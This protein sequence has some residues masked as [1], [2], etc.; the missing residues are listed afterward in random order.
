[1]R[2]SLQPRGFENLSWSSLHLIFSHIISPDHDIFPVNMITLPC[3]SGLRSWQPSTQ[4]TFGMTGLRVVETLKSFFLNFFFFYDR[5]QVYQGVYPQ[6]WTNWCFADYCLSAHVHDASWVRNLCWGRRQE[7]FFL[8]LR[9]EIDWWDSTQG[10][11]SR[12]GCL[13]CSW[14]SPL[15]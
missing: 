10:Q 13:V 14:P 5:T 1:M 11:I 4:P 7:C 2:N 6:L 3:I 15:W 8:K 9:S 12:W